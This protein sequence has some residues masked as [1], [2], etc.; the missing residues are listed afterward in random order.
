[1][2]DAIPYVF[3]L[4]GLV[5]LFG[6]AAL[7]NYGVGLLGLFVGGSAGYLIAPT[8]GSWVGV[9]GLGALAAAVLVGA[10][11]GVVVTY[12]LLSVAIATL[13]FVVGTFL[14]LAVLA[15]TL[16][17]GAW[18]LEWAAALGFGIIAAF[19]GMV[20]TKTTLILLTSFVGAA[21]TSRSLTMADFE[22]AQSGLALD[23]LLFDVTAP[24]FAGLLGLGILSQ[25]G[26]FKFGYVTRLLGLLPGAKV[27]RNR[28]LRAKPESK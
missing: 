13:S 7:A 27:L 2:V 18:Y 19:F 8:I 17:D 23:P 10:I 20:L 4:C 22:A 6:G 5:F 25:L 15:P 24:L 3:I 14:G 16:V 12:F 1:M 26:L 21:L 9:Q 11:L 28:G